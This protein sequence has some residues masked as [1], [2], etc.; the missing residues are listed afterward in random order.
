MFG[1][2]EKKC[3]LFIASASEEDPKIY[4]NG[5]KKIFLERVCKDF[6]DL[7]LSKAKGH[8]VN[9]RMFTFFDTLKMDFSFFYSKRISKV[10]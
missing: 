9:K 7:F 3:S 8:S 10:K 6:F 1:V 2:S 4:Q 5:K